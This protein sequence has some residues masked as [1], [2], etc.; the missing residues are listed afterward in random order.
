MAYKYLKYVALS[1][2]LM[3]ENTIVV[4]DW[5]LLPLLILCTVGWT[6]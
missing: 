1:V 2:V 6:V 5:K 4:L 3:N